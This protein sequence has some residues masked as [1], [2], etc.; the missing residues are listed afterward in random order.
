MAVE[1]KSDKGAKTKT[2]KTRKSRKSKRSKKKSTN[3]AASTEIVEETDSA[4]QVDIAEVPKTTDDPPGEKKITKRRTRKRK[5]S[6]KRSTS[7]A[8]I[9]PAQADPA[10][11][12]SDSII[13]EVAAT[14]L[15]DRPQADTA[16]ETFAFSRIEV[17]ENGDN[18]GP[19]DELEDDVSGDKQAEKKGKRS[20]RGGRSRKK[21]TK[22]ERS[23]SKKTPVTDD[24]YAMLINVSEG[25]EVRIAV[26]HNRRLEELFIERQSTQSMVGN[27][28]KGKVVNVEPSIQAV[29]VDFGQPKNGFLHISDVQPQYFPDRKTSN[30]D[31]GRKIPRHSRPPIQ[32]CFRRGSEVIVQ[33]TKEGLGTKG[34]T[35]TTYLSIP[36]RFL[37]MM[38]GMNK[39]GVSRKIEDDEVRR[40]MR[41]TLGQLE[42]PA[43][44]GFIMR[45]AGEGKPKRDLQRD[46][47]YLARLWKTVASRVKS[48]RAPAELYTESD[49]VTRTLRDVYTSS[50]SRIIVDDEGTTERVA[51][52]LK[53]ATPRTKTQVELHEAREP[54]FHKYGI[55]YEIEKMNMRHVPL[56]SGGSI[57]IDSTEAMVAID[58][59]SGKFRSPDDA[60]ETAFRINLEAAEEIAHQLRLR[61][62]GGLIVCDFIDMRYDRHKREVERTLRDALKKHKERA[63]TLRMSAFGLIEITRQRRGPSIKR[64]IY[65]DCPTC[66]GTGMVKSESSLVLEAL[67]IIRLATHRDDVHKITLTLPSDVAYRILN[68]RR[69]MIHKLE[70]DTGKVIIIRGSTTLSAGDIT[71][72]CED[73]NENLLKFTTTPR[74]GLSIT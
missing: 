33:I 8:D 56:A 16:D 38:P 62:L 60:E 27:I 69:A 2:K 67:R 66:K 54:L 68:H 42:L 24:D 32:D 14:T 9:E 71:F 29:F 58:V 19:D 20:R 45:T 74:E 34:P 73:A 61:D 59:N 48:Q 17:D 31:V 52:F 40:Q 65:T 5:K 57:V 28:Y 55:E 36:G 7:D 53:I 43:G 37:V 25:D 26:T 22:V 21:A 4:T 41:E 3:Q 10:P 49:L 64:E 12:E 13:D 51:E 30:E 23:S 39:L 70:E 11:I 15:Q 44:M 6:N 47:N 18:R 46:L 1:T 50:F 72:R 63:R 35:L